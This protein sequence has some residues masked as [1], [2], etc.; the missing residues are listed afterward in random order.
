MILFALELWVGLDP[1][2]LHAWLWS[3]FRTGRGICGAS[4][5]PPLTLPYS[6]MNKLQQNK[7]C[8]LSINLLCIIEA[9][10]EIIFF[11]QVLFGGMLKVFSRCRFLIWAVLAVECMVKRLGTICSATC[12]IFCCCKGSSEGE[13]MQWSN[14]NKSRHRWQSSYWYHL[15][16]FFQI[17]AVCE[18]KSVP[19]WREDATPAIFS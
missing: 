19:N 5:P 4:P 18:Q 15:T 1:P 10:L 9:L 6:G 12:H 14:C 13:R 17:P 8:R 16:K 11:L 7:C 2:W 3:V